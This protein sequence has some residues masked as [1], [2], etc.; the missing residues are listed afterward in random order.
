MTRFLTVVALLFAMTACTSG[1]TPKPKPAF[2][3]GTPVVP[4]ANQPP[5]KSGSNGVVTV[6]ATASVKADPDI[7]YFTLI[8]HA[9]A[10]DSAGAM[11]G[12]TI[13]SNKVLDKLGK[14]GVKKN[15]IQTTDFDVREVSHQEVDTDNKGKQTH[16]MVRDGFQVNNTMRVTVCKLDDLGKL[17]DAVGRDEGVLIGNP[18]FGSTQ[19]DKLLD[20]ARATAGKNAKVKAGKLATALDTEIG[21]LVEAKEAVAV[22]ERQLYTRSAEDAPGGAAIQSGTL[23]FSATVTVTYKVKQ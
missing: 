14:L 9:K 7:A 6:S 15:E 11:A 17:I 8:V 22:R 13:L 5:A 3:G 23:T 2:G 18:E 12:N 10:G 16:K 21:E 4:Q 1:D 19:Q 20:E